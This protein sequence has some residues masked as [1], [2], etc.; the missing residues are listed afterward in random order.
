M[1]DTRQG[2]EDVVIKCGLEAIFDISSNHASADT[3]PNP[4][5]QLDLASSHSE[6]E[7]ND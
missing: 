4:K 6:N 5:G 3:N 7:H 1:V 2:I